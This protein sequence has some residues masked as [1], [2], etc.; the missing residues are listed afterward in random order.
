VISISQDRLAGRPRDPRFDEALIEAVLDEIAAGAT[1][2]GLSL[3]R[4]ARRAGVSRNALYRRW[5][6][7]DSLYLDVLTAINTPIPQPENLS[8]RAGAELILAALI[9]RVRDERASKMLRALNAEAD[10]FP[11]L[12]R[13]YF[14]QVVAP[15]R[16]AMHLVLGRGVES[17]ELRGDIDMDFVS[18]LLVAPILARMASGNTADLNPAATAKEIVQVVFGGV[19]LRA[20][21]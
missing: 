18:E 9:E 8:A 4:V 19:A 3:V 7:K 1:L 14:Q 5:T 12:H 20:C 17:G 13:S 6:T 10:A 21:A 2:G 11:D 15:R 16:R